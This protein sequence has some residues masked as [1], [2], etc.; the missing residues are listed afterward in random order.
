[1]PNVKTAISLK[2][3]LLEKVDSAAQEMEM[4]RSHLFVLAVEEFLQRL[5]NQQLVETINKVH[6]EFR[7]PNEESN[8]T[9]MRR[10]QRELVKGTW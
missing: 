1:M 3:E 2:P 9:A 7:D 8:M 10:K 5:E 4:P 6:G